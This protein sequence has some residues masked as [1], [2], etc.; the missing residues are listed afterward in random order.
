MDLT[1]PQII[2][3]DKE[4]AQL[5]AELAAE[6]V[7]VKELEATLRCSENVRVAIRDEKISK[8][9]TELAKE[10]EK[11]KELESTAKKLAAGTVRQAIEL[12]AAQAT[13]AEAADEIQFWGA[14]ASDYFQEKHDIAGTVAR[15]RSANLDALHEARALEC[16]RLAENRRRMH[17]TSTAI[18]LDIE[19]A[20]HRA[21]KEGK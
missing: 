15:F 7:R 3:R 8:L 5:R 12:A 11:V 10:R 20:A 1:N 19:A 14:Y 16:E 2:M 13:I 21:R 18:L 6:R 9:E 4:I 17:D